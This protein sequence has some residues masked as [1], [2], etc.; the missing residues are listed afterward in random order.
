MSYKGTFAEL[1]AEKTGVGKNGKPW[2]RT[3]IRMVTEKGD[4]FGSTWGSM[5]EWQK[6]VGKFVAFDA[7]K[8]TYKKKDGSEGSS[9]SFTNIQPG[10]EGVSLTEQDFQ[11]DT[12]MPGQEPGPGDLNKAALVDILTKALH[13]AKNI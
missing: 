2:F 9:W 11:P 8:Q 7:E 13:I 12:A 5:G 6:H 4:W 10:G 3:T 1:T